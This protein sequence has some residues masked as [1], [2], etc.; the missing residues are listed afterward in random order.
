M[1]MKNAK[2]KFIMENAGWECSFGSITA[3][4]KSA[5][6]SYQE[7]VTRGLSSCQ[8]RNATKPAWKNPNRRKNQNLPRKRKQEVEKEA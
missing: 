6:S 5:Q 4:L 8:E 2:K 1:S 3:A 7:A